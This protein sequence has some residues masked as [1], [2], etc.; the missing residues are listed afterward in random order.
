MSRCSE[1][2]AR[3]R[4]IPSAS[5]RRGL[6]SLMKCRDIYDCRHLDISI[7]TT[8]FNILQLAT[9]SW[10]KQKSFSPLSRALWKCELEIKASP[11]NTFVQQLTWVH[12]FN[13]V[14]VANK[15]AD[16]L[17]PTRTLLR[18]GTRR[19]ESAARR[20]RRPNNHRTDNN[21]NSIGS[22]EPRGFLLTLWRSRVRFPSRPDSRK[23]LLGGDSPTCAS[24]KVFAKTECKT[25]LR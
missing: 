18:R 10:Q 25:V 16:C 19:L 11:I 17:D 6:L 2:P 14:H 4:P 20:S 21:G 22:R 9:Q 5:L 1:V 24:L 8:L 15:S 7:S 3:W 13:P 23:S 12:H